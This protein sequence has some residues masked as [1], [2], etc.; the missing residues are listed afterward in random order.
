MGATFEETPV[1]E[2][3]YRET[4]VYPPEEP[5]A[6]P[7]EGRERPC[8][9]IA[10]IGAGLFFV[11]A[12]YFDIGL[13]V[14]PLLSAGFIVAGLMT[15]GAGFFIP[16]GILGG[17]ALGTFLQTTPLAT[18]GDAQGGLFLVGFALGWGSITALTA[19]FSEETHWWALIPG[20]IMALI[21]SSLL[22]GGVMFSL[23]EFIGSAWPLGLI[24]VGIFLLLKR[25]RVEGQ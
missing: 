13:L 10:L 9:P 2:P 12:R 18:G 7:G 11:A 1:K 3:S 5:V 4:P 24:A 22:V 23:L 19:L 15:R 8:V 16:G 17:I 6:G 25:N 20:G 21:G 14:L